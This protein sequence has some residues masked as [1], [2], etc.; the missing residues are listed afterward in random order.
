MS[1]EGGGMGGF[2]VHPGVRVLRA[3][4]SLPVAQV[5]ADQ[6]RIDTFVASPLL[7]DV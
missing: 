6:T 1:G 7:A 3:C 2:G 5:A 4:V